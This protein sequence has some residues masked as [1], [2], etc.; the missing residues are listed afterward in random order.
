LKRFDEGTV[1]AKVLLSRNRREKGDRIGESQP[2]RERTLSHQ[3]KFR[4]GRKSPSAY[5]ADAL[6]PKRTNFLQMVNVMDP[7]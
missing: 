5:K 2:F 6:S 7:A 4:P 1:T 3:D